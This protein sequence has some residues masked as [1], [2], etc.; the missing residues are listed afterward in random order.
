MKNIELIEE[1]QNK[2][3]TIYLKEQL[4]PLRG[5]N[6]SYEIDNKP[7]LIWHGDV[8]RHCWCHYK[9]HF[10]FDDNIDELLYSSDEIVYFTAHLYL[11]R[12]YIS[13]PL[14]DAYSIEGKMIYPALYN[15]PRKR[16]DMYIGIV[17]EKI[18]NYWD[19]IGDLIAAFFPHLFK[20]N[21][22]LNTTIKGL[23]DKY[24][25]NENFEW[26]LNFVNN[27]YSDFN[28]QRINIVHYT[29][30]NTSTKSQQLRQVTDY[31]ETKL[32]S[33]KILNFPDYFKEMNELAKTG[34]IKTR[35]FLDDV[36]KVENYKCP[37]LS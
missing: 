12:P 29:S 6:D 8:T 33:E 27:E 18:Y 5:E 1:L 37:D 3:S 26:L 10:N 34:F 4:F 21:I 14:R 25:G 24:N 16:Y 28:T 20:G 7:I 17:F 23:K 36:N 9:A 19:R 11:Y 15:L 32:L 35:R 31:N 2:I 30:H 22:Y 13:T